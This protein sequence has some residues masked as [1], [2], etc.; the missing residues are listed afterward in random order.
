MGADPAGDL[1]R[2]AFL[3]LAG[4]ALA[5]GGL[6]A[7]GLAGCSSPAKPTDGS[8]PIPGTSGS[9]TTATSKAPATAAAWRDLAAALRGHLVQPDDPGYD[10]DRQLFNPRF[11]DL[12]PQGIAYCTEPAD[13]AAC[14]TFA[15]SHDVALAVRSG[16]HSFGG[17]SSGPGLVVDTTRMS[18]VTVND[19]STA[20]VGAGARLIDVY[21]GLAAQGRMIPAGSCPTVGIAGLTMG[22]GVGV[23][24]RKYGLTCDNLTGAQVVLADSSTIS[25]NARE[26]EDL[27]WALRGG[28][29]GNFGAVTSFTFTTHP[30]PDLVHASLEWPWG[31][32]PAVL[33]AWVA[34]V[35]AAPDELWSNCL[36]LA[37]YDKGRGV[38]PLL[39]VG[40]VWVGDSAGMAS[41][42]DALVAKVGSAPRSRAVQSASFLDTMRYEGGCSSLSVAECRLPSQGAAGKLEREGSVARSQY[43]AQPLPGDA[44][45]ALVDAVERRQA[46]PTL[47]Q[48]GVAFDAYGGAINR[49]AADATAF[50][51]R[52]AL[53]GV[54]YSGAWHPGTTGSVVADNQAWVDS[55]WQ[56]MR[57]HTDGGAYQ[58]YPDSQLAP[59]AWPTAYYGKNVARLRKVKASY[60]PERLFTFPQAIEPA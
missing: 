52:S 4:G 14:V 8:M 58:N 21:A 18:T 55:I 17:W 53:A 49:I 29:G 24:G 30:A 15:R 28:G 11:D 1:P 42:L 31:A 12:H 10:T 37:R 5:A 56:K 19:D 22:G 16:G 38:E 40:A 44:T 43:L 20:T 57:T 48:G 32:A 3:R 13:V 34:W 2:R 36:L 51:H 33:D 35:P 59:S 41:Q 27:F 54:L 39:R 47:G 50:V 7:G 6:A 26:H 25:C 60:D 9:A 45:A 23:L 46:D